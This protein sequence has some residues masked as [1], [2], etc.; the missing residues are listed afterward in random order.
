VSGREPAELFGIEHSRHVGQADPFPD[1][2]LVVR[3]QQRTKRRDAF[4]RILASRTGYGLQRVEQPDVTARQSRG[5]R[6]EM[7]VRDVMQHRL[8]ERD[9]PGRDGDRQRRSGE[10]LR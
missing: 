6:G 10:H 3:T 1:D 7:A 5:V 9:F 8:I 4:V 2:G